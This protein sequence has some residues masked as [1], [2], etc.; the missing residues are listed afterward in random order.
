M[1][2]S[3]VFLRA[4]AFYL[5]KDTRTSAGVK[6]KLSD[7]HY[8]TQDAGSCDVVRRSQNRAD[9]VELIAATEPPWRFYCIDFLPHN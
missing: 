2:C 3:P 7:F 6:K 4:F 8:G 9:V 1:S 5:I